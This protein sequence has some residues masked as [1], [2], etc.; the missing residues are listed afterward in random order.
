MAAAHKSEWVGHWQSTL[1][2]L[3]VTKSPIRK[4]K[5]RLQKNGKADLT[6]TEAPSFS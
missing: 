4:G 3:V 2:Q 6:V 5:T 1:G